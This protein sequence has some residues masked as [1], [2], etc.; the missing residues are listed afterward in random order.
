MCA[1]VTDIE[2]DGDRFPLDYRIRF[3]EMGSAEGKLLVGA[4]ESTTKNRPKR[5]AAQGK[6]TS[7]AFVTKALPTRPFFLVKPA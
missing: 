3:S 4:T 2:A 1:A 7:C 5:R 6:P